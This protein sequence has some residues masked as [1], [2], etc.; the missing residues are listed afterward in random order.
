MTDPT[1][2]L[3]DRIDALVDGQLDGGEPETGYDFDDPDFPVCPHCQR[4]WHGL[5]ITVRIERMRNYGVFDPNYKYSEDDSGVVC[6]GSDFIGPWA[7]AFQLKQMRQHRD[8]LTLM[9]SAPRSSREMWERAWASLAAP[10]PGIFQAY[11]D[12]HR[13]SH[14][15][16][17]ISWYLVGPGLWQLPDDPFDDPEAWSGVPPARAVRVGHGRGHSRVYF[18][19]DEIQEIRERARIAAQEVTTQERALPR[20]SSTPPMWA[21]D[22]TRSNR[23][24]NR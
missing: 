21:V 16:P 1:R 18:T 22:P 5:A 20:P 9:M 3:L 6:P 10:R 8:A 13:V 14:E 2:S 4:D 23:R 24:R 19:D 7:T 11:I 15:S 12:A 17:A